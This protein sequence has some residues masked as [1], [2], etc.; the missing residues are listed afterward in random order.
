M[1]QRVLFIGTNNADRTQMAEGYLRARYGD[2]CEACSAGIAL[3]PR[4][5]SVADESGPVS[6]ASGRRI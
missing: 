6:P 4:A 2:R 1:K 3:D 5:A